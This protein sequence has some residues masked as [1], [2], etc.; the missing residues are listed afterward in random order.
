MMGKAARNRARRK[1]ETTLERQREAVHEAIEQILGLQDAAELK[2]VLE[3]RPELLGEMAIEE[4]RLIAQSPGYGPLI[5]LVL[6]LLEDARNDPQAAWEAFARSRETADAAGRHLAALDAEIDEARDAGELSRAL[7]LIE[8]ALWLAR[9]I[10][11]GLSVCDL[12]TKRGLLLVELSTADRAGEIEAA[13]QAFEEALEVSLH[14][15]Q[16]ARILMLR[17]L[18]Y[19]E[20]VNGDP[21]E[22]TDRSI[23]SVQDGLRQLEGSGNDGLRAMMQTNLAVAMIRR[24]HDRAAAARAAAELCRQAL[25]YRSPARDADEWAYS[26]INLGYALQTLA[27]LGEVEP[28]DARTAYEEVLAHSDSIAD[29]ALLGSAHQ[30]LGRLELQAARNSPEERSRLTPRGAWMSSSTKRHR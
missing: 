27:E 24:R 8:P 25:T 13:L 26:Q 3:R 29:G 11:Y 21:A 6:H 2:Q 14:G 12:L 7:D 30:A 16:A 4:V 20:R 18:A 17:G 5:A 9:E 15:E 23:V 1:S 10:G 28:E 19:S 22:N